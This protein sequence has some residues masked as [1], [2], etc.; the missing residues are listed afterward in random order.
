MVVGGGII[1]GCGLPIQFMIMA[2]IHTFGVIDIIGMEI[3][4]GIIL[5]GTIFDR[6]V[7]L[8]RQLEVVLQE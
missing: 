5:E 1:L 7:L 3:D 2:I 4:I 8:D 6:S